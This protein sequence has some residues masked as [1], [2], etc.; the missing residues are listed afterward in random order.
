MQAESLKFAVS[1]L[2][3]QSTEPP[4]ERGRGIDGK[5]IWGLDKTP[6]TFQIRT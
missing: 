1:S 5:G 3:H 6:T 4:G 2:E